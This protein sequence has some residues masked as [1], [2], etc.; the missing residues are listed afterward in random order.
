ML[1][2]LMA[3]AIFIAALFIET[4]AA[5][6]L[7]ESSH[8]AAFREA[9]E[10]IFASYRTGLAP[11]LGYGARVAWHSAPQ[12]Y[13][14]ASILAR[15]LFFFFFIAQTRKAM[16]PY[17]EPSPPAMSEAA[18]DWALPV[19]L[20]ALGALFAGPTLLPFLTVP[21]AFYLG[22]EKLMGR[23]CWFELSRSYTFNLLWLGAAVGGILLLQR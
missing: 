21:A 8:A 19:G 17:E 13:I 4:L 5:L 9:F 23:P 2:A 1:R 12:W 11:L 3:D 14:D 20:C 6:S 10:P 7:L 22:L 15:I 16:A 18:V